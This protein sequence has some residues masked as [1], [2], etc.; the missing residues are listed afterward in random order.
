MAWSLALGWVV[1]MSYLG[2][3]LGQQGF[4]G[5]YNILAGG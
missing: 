5:R 2:S 3:V 4:I 1:T